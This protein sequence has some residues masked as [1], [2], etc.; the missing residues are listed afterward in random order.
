MNSGESKI[1]IRVASIGDS[2]ELCE[3]LNEIIRVGGTTAYQS[4]FSQDEFKEHYLCGGDCL[5]CHVAVDGL[6]RLAGFQFLGRNAQLVKDWADIATF[7]RITP[8]IAGVGTALFMKTKQYAK[9]SD[10]AAINATIRAD[11]KSGLAY[12]GRMGFQTYDVTKDVP[13]NDGAKVDRIWK[14]FIVG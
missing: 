13:L 9:Q 3:I 11:N 2:R 10:I 5:C 6:G 4:V 14:R 1:S 7:A 8:K 12:Y